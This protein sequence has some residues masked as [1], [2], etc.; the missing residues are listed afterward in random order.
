MNF[1]SFLIWVFFFYL[2]AF[3]LSPS[4]LGY[5]GIFLFFDLGLIL[6]F[7][8]LWFKSVGFRLLCFF[9]LFFDLGLLFLFYCLWF[10]F[11]GFSGWCFICCFMI[12]GFFLH[13]IAC[14]LSPSGLGCDRF[15]LFFD[16]ELLSPFYCLS[17]KSVGFRLWR[18]F[19]LF[20]CFFASLSILLPLV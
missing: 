7:Y 18:M 10:K 15:F 14:G 12:W 19:F 1:F 9:L 4:G 17:F 3:N 16:L 6:P 13:F 11:V 2:I 20:F 5:D 8:C